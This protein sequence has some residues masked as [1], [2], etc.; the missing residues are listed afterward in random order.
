M[1]RVSTGFYGAGSNWRRRL[2]EVG[3]HAVAPA[4]VLSAP[5]VAFLSFHEYAYHRPE[6]LV[7]LAGIGGISLALGMLASAGAPARTLMLAGVV[8]F[9]VDVQLPLK[10]WFLDLGKATLLTAGFLLLTV[11]L[12][13]LRRHAERIISL[14]AAT[15]LASTLLLPIVESQ[16]I[17]R[18][19]APPQAPSDLPLIVHLILDEHIGIDGLPADT[20]VRELQSD[21]RSFYYSNGFRVFEAAYSE[22]EDTDRSLGHLLNFSQGKYDDDLAGPGASG[23]Q[24][25]LSRNAYFARMRQLGYALQVYQT[26]FLQLCSQT[27]SVSCHT[28]PATGLG[29]LQDAPLRILEKVRL[30]AG[31]YLSRSRLHTAATDWYDIARGTLETIGIDLPHSVWF[32]RTTPLNGMA[33]MRQVAQALASAT[34]GQL[35]FAHFMLPHWPHVYDADC[36]LLPVDRWEG[37]GGRPESQAARLAA[38]AGYGRQLR[39]TTR[40]IGEIVDAIP[41]SL[42]NDAIVIVHGDHGS[43]LALADDQSSSVGVPTTD[44]DRDSYSTLFAVRAPDIAAGPDRH[45]VPITCLLGRLVDAGFRS[46]EDLD[47]CAA[48][49]VVFVTGRPGQAF[50][51]VLAPFA[52]KPGDLSVLP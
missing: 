12:W 42:R 18:A 36:A 13:L 17:R 41:S 45:F 34:R 47:H 3:R 23:F 6:I 22:H 14:M 7:C 39:C 21:L 24:N 35:Y 16:Q 33:A 29:V 37:L 52:A 43:R 44:N 15:V 19:P 8:T 38:Y 51:R 2:T 48:P 28:S 11:L 1:S 31:A 30:V 50:K 49:P 40:M 25:G 26:D 9:F 10:V 46:A 27:E 20:T 32:Y 4:L 5:F